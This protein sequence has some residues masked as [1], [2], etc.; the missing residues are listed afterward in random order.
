MGREWGWGERV[1][2]GIWAGLSKR[3]LPTLGPTPS[4]DASSS[5]LASWGSSLKLSH[6]PG[7][8]RAPELTIIIVLSLPPSGERGF[9]TYLAKEAAEAQRGRWSCLRSPSKRMTQAVSK[10][11]PYLPLTLC[12]LLHSTVKDPPSFIIKQTPLRLREVKTLRQGHTANPKWGWDSRAG[13][14]GGRGQ[15]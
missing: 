11:L 4:Q 13:R 3:R 8:C 6:A 14:Q 1:S 10:F 12:P 2:A 7:A 15:C 5:G 9:Q